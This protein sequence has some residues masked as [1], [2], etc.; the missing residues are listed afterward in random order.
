MSFLTPLMAWA[1][2]ALAAGPLIIHLLNR[3][4][5]TIVDWAAMD[6]LREAMQRQR[7]ILRLRDWLL[8]ALRTLCVLLFGLAMAQPFSESSTEVASSG[9]PVHAILVI[10]NSLSMSD[11]SS[12]QQ[13]LAEAKA[14]AKNLVK[15]PLLKGSKFSVLPLCSDLADFTFDAYGT[16]ADAED[17]IDEIEVLDRTAGVTKVVELAAEAMK[18]VQELPTKRVVFFG[19]QQ[20]NC[21]PKGALNSSLL[22]SVE[23]LNVVQVGAG[24]RE[25]A[26]IED[27]RVQDEVADVESTTVFIA[28]VRY[29]GEST[30]D[31]VPIRLEIDGEPLLSQQF[32]TLRPGQSREVIFTHRFDSESEAAEAG[33]ARITAVIPEDSIPGDKLRGDNKRYLV[34]PVL[35]GVPVVFIDQYGKDEDPAR[36]R[37]GETFHVRRLLTPALAQESEDRQLIRVHHVKVDEVDQDLLSEARLVVIAGIANPGEAVPDLR[38]YVRQGG[39]LFVAAGGNFNPEEWNEMGWDKGNGVLA[40]PLQALAAGKLPGKGV[41]KLD[42]F[43]ISF[44]SLATES[45]LLEEESEQALEDLYRIPLFFK[46]V[47]ANLSDEEK[48]EFLKKEIRKIEDARGAGDGSK[49]SPATGPKP[50]TVAKDWLTWMR[51]AAPSNAANTPEQE[52]ASLLPTVLAKYTNGHPMLVERRIGRGKSVLFTSGLSSDWNTLTRT[53]AVLV[54]D[55]ILRGMLRETLQKVNF[56]DSETVRLSVSAEQRKNEFSLER[57][58]GD[59]AGGADPGKEAKESLTPEA[60]GAGG[61]EI[62]VR[63]VRRRGHYVISAHENDQGSSGFGVVLWKRPLAVNGPV[64]ES[65]LEMVAPDDLKDVKEGLD[66]KDRD[67]L[68]WVSSGQKV[69]LS[70]GITGRNSWKKWMVVV[71]ALLLLEVLVLSWSAITGMVGSSGEEASPGEGA[72]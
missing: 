43:F 20:S 48:T 47:I 55:R 50:R 23:K 56:T 6:F 7:R 60:R 72:A 12:G 19:D 5:F 38:D 34:V 10:D 58:R 65:E 3:R 53:N 1:G 37:Y 66:E 52:A 13:A 61:D 21:W 63:R 69:S 54:L 42:P 14:A 51:D 68:G 18:G 39:Q 17:A 64:V 36:N 2:L 44:D 35:S 40:M 71:L 46:A 16:V 32:V 57:P 30:Q 27:L 67:K 22:A 45:F 4:R 8:L 41:K 31:K 70:G 49:T 24:K 28:K 29:E 25:N 59:K 26:W 9:E 62:V 11:S 33:F 15:N